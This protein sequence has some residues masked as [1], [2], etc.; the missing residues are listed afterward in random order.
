MYLY[1]ENWDKALEFADK[2]IEEKPALLNL[3]KIPTLG[4]YDQEGV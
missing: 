3:S 1:M 2:V 4:S